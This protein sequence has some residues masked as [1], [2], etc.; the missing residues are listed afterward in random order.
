MSATFGSGITIRKGFF[1]FT[2]PGEVIVRSY[3]DTTEEIRLP[4]KKRKHGVDNNDSEASPADAPD[5]EAAETIVSTDYLKS[6]DPKLAPYPLDGLDTWRSLTT[7]ITPETLTRVLG[8]DIQGDSR[9]DSLM[10]SLADEF[11]G[12]AAQKT[13]K[14]KTFW[15]KPRPGPTETGHE[16]SDAPLSYQTERLLRFVPVDVK[17]SWRQGAT[18]EELTRDSRDKTWVSA[19]TASAS[20]IAL[21]C[22]SQ[23]TKVLGLI[24]GLT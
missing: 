24:G 6:L 12:E 9:C 14:G 21:G 17:K 18:G 10:A 2:R 13:S 5:L 23:L 16:R 4:S 8:Q 20:R 3:D 22:R 7:F 1:R 19:N 15:G 11:G